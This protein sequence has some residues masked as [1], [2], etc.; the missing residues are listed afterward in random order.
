MLRSASIT[1]GSKIAIGLAN[2]A[3]NNVF[4]NP[5][6]YVNDGHADASLAPSFTTGETSLALFIRDLGDLAMKSN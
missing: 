3:G 4:D 2:E 6:W 1:D 5:K